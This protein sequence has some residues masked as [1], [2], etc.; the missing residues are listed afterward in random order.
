MSKKFLVTGASGFVGQ[1][2]IERLVAI[3]GP[4]VSI[5]ALHRSKL[6]ISE[7]FY[8][9]NVRWIRSDITRDDLSEIFFGVETVYHLAGFFSLGETKEDRKKLEDVNVIGAERV[10]AESLK[11]GVRKFIYVS[12]ISVCELTESRATSLFSRGGINKYGQSKKRAEELILNLASE[13]FRVTILRPCALFGERHFG[14]IF[15]LVKLISLGRMVIFGSGINI[16]NFYYI[17]DFIEVLIA[18]ELNA[19]E[20][21]RV[22]NCADSSCNLERLCFYISTALNNEGK[23]RKIPK[24]LGF[25][26]AIFIDFLSLVLNKSLP[27]SLRRYYAM[28]SGVVYSTEALQRDLKVNVSYGIHDG[29]VRT[30][31]W[32]K[33]EDLL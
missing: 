12:S 21:R 13:D 25:M 9:N 18:S 23:V 30:I 11:S 5:I 14:S 2:L 8:G 22:Y 10:A 32:F 7:D 28:T 17:R 31:E 19:S 3:Y 6:D 27:F 26:S 4:D 33:E 16:V 1:Y 20:Y 29:I 24:L 15:E